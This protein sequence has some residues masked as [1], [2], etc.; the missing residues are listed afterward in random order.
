VLWGGSLKLAR[1]FHFESSHRLLIWRFPVILIRQALFIILIIVELIWQCQRKTSWIIVGG[2]LL[3]R[4]KG[5]VSGKFVVQANFLTFCHALASNILFVK[6]TYYFFLA[7][8]HVSGYG[9]NLLHLLSI[10]FFR[11]SCFLK[12]WMCEALLGC[13]PLVRGR[14]HHQ[15]EQALAMRREMWA[16][17]VDYPVDLVTYLFILD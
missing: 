11:G 12:P 7:R 1:R 9:L 3:Q 2:L 4:I 6:C 16:R 14:P 17:A 5:I 10:K 8:R 13:A 15:I